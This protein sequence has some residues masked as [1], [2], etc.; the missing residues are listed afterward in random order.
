VK[1][2]LTLTTLLI[3]AGLALFSLPAQ[4]AEDA[5]KYWPA[6]RGPLGTG[7]SPN[8]DPPVS[9]S[10]TENVKW[11]SAIPGKGHSSPIVWGE[12]IVITSAVETDR[13]AEGAPKEGEKPGRRPG[14]RWMRGIRT[15]KVHCFLV[16]AYDRSDGSKV[17]EST[18]FEEWPSDA[19]H[20]DGSWASNTPVT[21][22]KK[23]VAYFGSRGIACLSMK[24]EVLWKKNIGRMKK[25]MSFGDGASPALHKN[26][27]VVVQDHEGPS[28][29]T[30]L[31]LASGDEVWRADR[32]EQSTWATPFF[33]RVKG[34]M[35]ILTS[36]TRAIRSYDLETGKVLWTLRGMT[37]NVIPT[38]V[39]G[40]GLVYFTSGFRGSAATAVRFADA[41]GDVTGTDAVAW[42]YSGS[43]PYTPSPVLVGDTLYMLRRNDSI[44]T[45]LNA[46][47]GKVIYGPERFRDVGTVYACLTAAKNR[48][49]MVGKK[50]LT[51][52]FEHGSECKVLSRNRLDDLF[53]AS[54]AIVGKELFLRGEKNLYCLVGGS[55]GKKKPKEEDF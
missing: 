51:Y 19:T 5:E 34:R 25:R 13:R 33:L 23:I 32:D 29:I 47:T 4:G 39:V 2:T 38:P 26:R 6:W 52:V 28:F 10:E 8:G 14:R 55:T 46:K 43:T 11:K 44:L 24:G 1:S 36:G 7:V 50:G 30:V 3:L 21:D 27:I 37:Q 16:C 42:H 41:R 54:P 35:Q 20:G 15:D 22:G 31:D 9:W 48:F 17:W 49:Y 12:L 45:A 18:V 53:S 40:H